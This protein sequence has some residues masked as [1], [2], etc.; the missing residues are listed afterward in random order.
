MKDIL[1]AIVAG[2]IRPGD[3]IP[4]WDV[5]AARYQTDPDD[6]LRALEELRTH[7]LTNE[8]E[9]A[10]RAVL[11]HGTWQASDRKYQAS[12]RNVVSRRP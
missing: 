6:V 2:G 12:E 9:G 4:R 10:V 3:E 7:G 5:L 11:E 1:A 8:R